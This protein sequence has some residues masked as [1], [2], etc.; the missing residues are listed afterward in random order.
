MSAIL[1]YDGGCGLCH[2]AVRFLLKRDRGAAFRFAPLAGD[3]FA[4]EVSA[5]VRAA[6]PDSLVLRLEDGTLLTRSA[7]VVAMLRRLGGAWTW[8]GLALRLVPPLLR[9]AGYDAVAKV[10]HRLF[11][12]PEG[13]CPL[14]PPALRDRFLP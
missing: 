8:L 1:F 2:R 4:R 5:P 11:K 13:A 10:R 7:A 6:L 12:T 14:V 9:D 3:T